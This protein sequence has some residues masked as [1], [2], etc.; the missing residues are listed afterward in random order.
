MTESLDLILVPTDFSPRSCEAFSWAATLAKQF[1]AKILIVHVISE[2]QADKMVSVPGNPWERVLEK[3][4]NK[5]VEDFNSCLVSEFGAEQ[6]KETLVAV[7][8]AHTRIVDIAKER[9]ASVIVMTTHGRTGLA[10]FVMGSVAEK[11]MRS[12]PCPVFSVKPR[13]L[14]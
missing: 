8:Q 4:H 12:A 6:D 9:N 7:G 1:D 10:H 11:V 3:G 13:N 5:M 2:E 14:E